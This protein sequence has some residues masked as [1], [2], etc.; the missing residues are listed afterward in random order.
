MNLPD[1][2]L[3]NL[4]NGLGIV[5]GFDVTT[6]ENGYHIN[7]V[8]IKISDICKELLESRYENNNFRNAMRKFVNF[9][10]PDHL[11]RLEMKELLDGKSIP[12][13]ENFVDDIDVI[14]QEHL[15]NDIN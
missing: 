2:L 1:E 9:T 4:V 12:P 7:G 15:T 3:N 8:P 5:L 6:N 13:I 10:V 11:A 14:S